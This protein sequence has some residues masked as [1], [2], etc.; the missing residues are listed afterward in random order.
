[1]K[2]FKGLDTLS[3]IGGLVALLLLG[4]LPTLFTGKYLGATC[5]FRTKLTRA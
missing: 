4:V 3:S 2:A 5:D 1:M